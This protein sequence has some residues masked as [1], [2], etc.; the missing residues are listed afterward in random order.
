MISS[1]STSGNV[2]LPDF[3]VAASQDAR[4]RDG[5]PT[6]C[7]TSN[8]FAPIGSICDAMPVGG[9]GNISSHRLV[10][11]HRPTTAL[12]HAQGTAAKSY[13]QLTRQLRN[14]YEELSGLL[15]D[16]VEIAPQLSSSHR[17]VLRQTFALLDTNLRQMRKT[18]ALDRDTIASSSRAENA[19]MSYSTARADD[20]PFHLHMRNIPF[21]MGADEFRQMI[22]CELG[23]VIK[24]R[25]GVDKLQVKRHGGY[26]F[27][28]LLDGRVEAR[29]VA[30]RFFWL[31]DRK[32]F[33]QWSVKRN[34][35][36]A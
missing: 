6:S 2:Q 10:H 1:A 11:D 30:Q 27:V 13:E 24:V 28:T 9:G 5:A 32:I 21:E 8:S 16:S 15:V 36:V 35:I 14:V 19:D 23:A 26:A 20:S 29:L 34:D 22:E 17:Q 31:D 7:S 3:I 33:V 12:L 4:C 18:L 25:L